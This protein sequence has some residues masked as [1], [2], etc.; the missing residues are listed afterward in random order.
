MKR[1]LTQMIKIQDKNSVKRLFLFKIPLIKIKNK[2]F[3]TKYYFLNF[4]PF[5]KK[6][7]YGNKEK[8]YLFGIK[9]FKRYNVPSN[10][11]IKKLQTSKSSKGKIL[12][13][14]HLNFLRKDMGCSNY[15]YEVAKLYKDL[16]YSVD[17]FTS[18]IVSDPYQFDYLEQL[19]ARDNLIDNFYMIRTLP[20]SSPKD[21]FDLGWGDQHVFNELY[22]I[23]QHNDYEYVDIHYIQW[24]GLFLNKP[25]SNKTK[26][27]YHCHDTN[28]FQYFYQNNKSNNNF[29]EISKAF[30]WELN[31]IK[32]FDKIF[33]ISFDE[34]LF[35]KKFFPKKDFY[36]MPQ[37]LDAHEPKSKKNKSIDVLFL[38]HS[39]QFNLE[40]L[41][42][43]LKD[44]YPLLIKQF[45]ITIC[46]RVT[47]MLKEQYPKY[48]K[49]IQSLN[50]DLIEFVDDLNSLYDD[51]KVVIVPLQG[52]TG[53]K[54]KTIEAMS[55]GIPIVSTSFGVDGFPDKTNNGILV[56]DN[57]EEFANYLNKLLSDEDYYNN[58]LMK[59]NEYYSQLFSRDLIKRMLKKALEE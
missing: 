30:N 52:G 2:N 17:F 32:I 42:W 22:K 19:N 12:I 36:F 33:C 59:I 47:K 40:G 1:L 37:P 57:P 49:T 31:V 10:D 45:H 26:L 15:V 53:M 38:G 5:F 11:I 4:L 41:L 55:Y 28:F 27:I 56:S 39:N 8:Y 20:N 46:G 54:I 24:G 7:V 51:T 34:L 13:I 35:W 58:Q 14:F 9:I 29:N 50:F 25:L 18:N 23:I 21:S 43:F 16:G 3:K 48:Y 44:I 6:K